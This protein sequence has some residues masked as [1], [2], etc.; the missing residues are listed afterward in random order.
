MAYGKK[1]NIE[2]I[3]A[4]IQKQKPTVLS[5]RRSGGSV[6]CS[7][8]CV[9][10]S[11]GHGARTNDDLFI[12]DLSNG[13][14]TSYS[15]PQIENGEIA[16]FG[17]KF[18]I[19]CKSPNEFREFE[20][21]SNCT[22]TYIRTISIDSSMYSS[23][24]TGVN[25]VNGLTAK[26]ANTLIIG[27]VDGTASI[28]GT[29]MEVDIS[30]STAV[31]TPLFQTGLIN[32]DMVYI[33][34]SNTIATAEFIPGFGPTGV[35]A[36]HYDYNGTIL[37]Q[38]SVG[39]GTVGYGMFCYE[40]KV[41]V[42]TSSG[43]KWFDL[44][45]Y[46][47]QSHPL[48]IINAGDQASSSSCCDT[49]TQPNLE[50]Y[51]IGD[52]GPEGGII[53][54]V[55]LSH[56]QNNGVN[57]TNYY[58]E[59]AKDDIA[60]AGTPNVGFNLTCGN[61]LHPFS[62]TMRVGPFSG[63]SAQGWGTV[64]LSTANALSVGDEIDWLYLPSGT[65]ITAIVLGTNQGILYF[66]NPFH[67][68][69]L[70]VSPSG[71]GSPF[72][73]PSYAGF[74]HY[75]Q[76]GNWVTNQVN[77]Y[78]NSSDYPLPT[79]IPQASVSPGWSIQGAEWGVHNKPNI[80]TSIDFDTG[81]NNTDNIDVYPLSPTSSYN[82]LGQGGVNPWL[83][84]HDIAA[85]LC[86]Q[87][88]ISTGT[89][90]WFL[91]SL[92]E[93]QEIIDQVGAL[94]SFHPPGQNSEH[95]YWTSSQYRQDP[96]NP[97]QNPDMY[98]WAFDTDN[99]SPKM[100]YRCHALSVRP[101]R[102]FECEPPPPCPPPTTCNFEYNYRDGI[103]GNLDGFFCS[104]N[105]T[106]NID[107][108][109]TP[110]TMWGDSD[111]GCNN[112]LYDPSIHGVNL[113]DSII[114]TPAIWFQISNYDVL[115][116]HY[117]MSNFQNANS[118]YIITLYDANHNYIGKWKYDLHVIFDGSAYGSHSLERPSA[119]GDQVT[120]LRLR[121]GQ[122]LDG[123]FPIVNYRG[124][125]NDSGAGGQ[126]ITGSSTGVFM[127]LEFDGV[128]GYETACNA[129]SH[130]N[131]FPYYTP[132]GLND[133]A[134]YCGTIYSPNGNSWD[135][136]IIPRAA[137][138][139]PIDYTT[140]SML[141]VYATPYDIN[142]NVFYTNWYS[143]VNNLVFQNIMELSCN[144]G[145]PGGYQIGDIGPA[146]GIIVATPWMNA[147]TVTPN[148]AGA[149]HT[150]YYYEIAPSDTQLVHEWGNI[151]IAS[152]AQQNL[153]GEG[154][155]ANNTDQ[156]ILNYG[157][158]NMPASGTAP[159]A[160]N[161]ASVFSLNNY[162]DWF[163]P[164]VEEFWFIRNNIPPISN[165]PVPLPPPL[166]APLNINNLYW[167]SNFRDDNYPL[168]TYG[169]P[170]AADP[171]NGNGLAIGG[172]YHSNL[173]G[174]GQSFD[175]NRLAL[176]SDAASTV[177]LDSSGNFAAGVTV[178][179]EIERLTALKVRLMRKFECYDTTN[180][181]FNKRAAFVDNNSKGLKNRP[182]ETGPFAILGYYPLFDTVEGAEDK[183]PDSSGYHIHE[184][185]GKEYYMPNG[186]IMDET[187]FHGDWTSDSIKTE[188]ADVPPM[189][190]YNL[191]IHDSI[192]TSAGGEPETY[193]SG[194][195]VTEDVEIIEEVET[196]VEYIDTDESKKE[197]Q[198]KRLPID[199]E[200]PSVQY[201]TVGTYTGADIGCA[202]NGFF[203]IAFHP[204]S[205][206]PTN[207]IG[208]CWNP[209][210]EFNLQDSLGNFIT[211][212]G[213]TPFTPS[214]VSG[215]PSLYTWNGAT[216]TYFGMIAEFD[217]LNAGIYTFTLVTG[218][219]G[220]QTGNNLPI[221]HTMIVHPQ[222]CVV[223]CDP[224]TFAAIPYAYQTSW[225]HDPTMFYN[226]PVVLPSWWA[227]AGYTS[228]SSG[229]TGI[230]TGSPMFN[231]TAN[232]DLPNQVTLC[233][234]CNDWQT[235]YASIP[236]QFDNRVL[237]W[238]WTISQ[239]EALCDCCGGPPAQPPPPGIEEIPPTGTTQ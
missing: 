181:I 186:L 100:S 83:N 81:H 71:A 50:C 53:F 227:S 161:S 188:Y 196:F 225:T 5:K 222:G 117:T 120:I 200:L 122:H 96:N 142:P 69:S 223:P 151:G 238:G 132:N 26:D 33:P 149:N 104:G 171:Q 140:G 73:P 189:D 74:G 32:G 99:S 109:L 192:R 135:E 133:H 129:Y 51:D 237:D 114:G 155:G 159:V 236:G 215:G 48:N 127:K 167:T 70:P 9:I 14:T 16:K 91:P 170:L 58:Y 176:A 63:G 169:T 54:A 201:G 206:D 31:F 4:E 28:G 72:L 209:Y 229:G 134:H 98:S 29:L 172:T 228:P 82:S 177:T 75:N 97:V 22:A 18:W 124:H 30:S 77:T 163:L 42:N 41:I 12:T 79:F 8:P 158:P 174:L 157:I 3:E 208:G 80:Q 139:S 68:A 191:K 217:N 6:D 43:T 39:G 183:S 203:R 220:N 168:S 138:S 76:T 88:A 37:G 128:I 93:F 23:S 116:N 147:G 230:P 102:R 86:K 20:L 130:G 49:P 146:G 108:L 154:E 87:Q 180:N 219:C 202:G 34:S 205:T 199:W 111:E 36:A 175:Q 15:H 126:F 119:P 56:P 145:P 221:T 61:A 144:C 179:T 47:V 165:D 211:L 232:Y 38:V 78:T 67:W 52:T 59:V 110:I 10:L 45:T 25:T 214:A 204:V 164:S 66:S 213:G 13:F 224:V 118:G 55:P 137:T 121:N 60:I 65:T 112:V 226:P 7:S 239:A 148:G 162:D 195:I 84:T 193:F 197:K 150:K 95:L 17:N 44:D 136:I 123:N 210:I 212:T 92:G 198:L 156:M 234:W 21:N 216:S 207:Q 107:Y 57:Q 184:F 35:V 131:P 19:H 125:Y 160:F 166:Y 11:I 105:S 1:E 46:T 187:Q 94:V 218:N 90:D 2:K 62:A 153:P 178:A 233:E 40:E 113:G 64:S 85:T 235:N 231:P 152:F 173:T 141:P 182:S 24:N 103:C 143:Q 106:Q 89:G 194:E 190:I 101:I 115:G 27:S 185:S